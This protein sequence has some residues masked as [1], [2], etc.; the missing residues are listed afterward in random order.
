MCL[1]PYYVYHPGPAL[2]VRTPTA[3]SGYVETSLP[4]TGTQ[5]GIDILIRVHRLRAQADLIMRRPSDTKAMLCS[6]LDSSEK[7]AIAATFGSVSLAKWREQQSVLSPQRSAEYEIMIGDGH[8]TSHR[9]PISDS[10]PSVPLLWPVVVVGV[11][12]GGSGY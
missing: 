2:A 11:Y 4:H 5:T 10:V 1:L 8:T 3:I 12:V 7:D 9:P 6:M